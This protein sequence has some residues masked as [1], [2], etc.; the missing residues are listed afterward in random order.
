MSGLMGEHS[1]DWLWRQ[2]ESYLAARNPSAA[3]SAY[4]AVVAQQPGHAL[5][6]LRLSTLA[7]QQGR[8]RDSVAHLLAITASRPS[9]PYL[10]AMVAGMLHRLG[11]SRVALDCVAHPAFLSFDD[12]AVLEEMASL[13]SQLGDMTTAY[14]LLDAADRHGPPPGANA[15]YLRATLQLFEGQLDASDR[16]LEACLAREPSHAQAHWALSRVRKQTTAHNHVERLRRVL[17]QRADD[18]GRASLLF[19]LAKE[20]DDINDLVPAWEALAAGCASKRRLLEYRSADEDAAFAALHAFAARAETAGSPSPESGAQ[21][22]FIVGLPRTGTTLLERILGGHPL[23]E[24]AGELD[25]LA[26]Q[27][28]W[29][30]NRFSKNY[31]DAGLFRAASAVDF[32]ELGRRYLDHSQWRANGKPFYT[33]KMPLNF[34]HVGFIARALPQARILHMVRNPM[35]TCFSNLKELFTDAYPYSYALDELAAHYG[36]YRRL[37]AHWH[38][39]L[40]GRILDVSYESLVTEPMPAART[41]LDFCGL[42]W[43]VD[44]VDIAANRA[45]VSTASSAQV[46]QPIHAGA[47]E[48]WRRYAAPLEPL[49][50]RLQADGWIAP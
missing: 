6:R 5:A 40:P 10:L 13:A 50:Q 9:D 45:S 32:D 34:L 30:A 11:E 15:L 43:C 4:A 18:A 3:E 38:Q 48:S 37:M 24:N 44:V 2:G 28:R 22:I 1:V 12:R 33:D 39:Q 23:V 17:S 41:I 42:E 19:G 7:T 21:P 20:L 29:C 14:S 46:R 36:R 8:Y 31:L 27:L 25:D 35:D 49:R 26:L 16:S 47:V